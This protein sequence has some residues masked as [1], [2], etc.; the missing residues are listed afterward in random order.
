MARAMEVTRLV[1]AVRAADIAHPAHGLD[2][3]GAAGVLDLGAQVRDVHVDVVGVAHVLVAECLVRD[4][5][6][7]EHGAGVCHKQGEDVELAGGQRDGRAADRGFAAVG[8]ECDRSHGERGGGGRGGGLGRVA[9]RECGSIGAHGARPGADAAN[10]RSRPHGLRA[11]QRHADPCEQLLNRKWLGQVIVG[12]GVEPG[13]LVHHGVARGDHDYRH[14][15]VLADAPQHLHAV[16][17]RQQ[18]VEQN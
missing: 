2:D 7:R 17:L 6:A 16:E 9:S 13:H 4:A 12:T 1:S 15:L 8:V 11:L 5:L 3:A 18:H 14:I 10:A